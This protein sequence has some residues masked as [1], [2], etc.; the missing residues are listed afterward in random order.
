[1]KH[2][3][4]IAVAV[5]LGV[6]LAVPQVATAA[7]RYTAYVACGYRASAPPATSCHKSGHIG[8]FFRA[9]N[10]NVVFRTCVTF[11]NGQHLCT[12][13]S[14]AKK[15]QF[16]VNKL[17]VGSKGTLKVRWK[18]NGVVVRKYSITVN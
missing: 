1:M 2:F 13:K 9:N 7:N 3:R 11:P 8:A 5:M 14:T 12:A 6:L 18:V 16:Y 10:R 15:G 17:T 4:L